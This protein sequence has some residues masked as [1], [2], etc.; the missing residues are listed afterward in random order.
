MV[1]RRTLSPD[2]VE[3]DAFLD[4]PISSQCLYF[5]LSM[6]ANSDGFGSPKR[7]IR[8]MGASE[9]SLKRSSSNASFYRS[10]TA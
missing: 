6:N 4:M 3:H 2:I 7:I 1:Q 10:G 9:D 5:H 8:I